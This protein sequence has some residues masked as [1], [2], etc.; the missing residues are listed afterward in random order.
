[1]NYRSHDAA[2]LGHVS[3]KELFVKHAALIFLLEDTDEW[4]NINE[5]GN[6]LNLLYDIFLVGPV[7]SSIYFQF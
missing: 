6:S 1:M 7:V 3:S 5:K 2:P 4:W